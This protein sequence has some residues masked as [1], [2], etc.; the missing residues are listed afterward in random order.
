MKKI[1]TLIFILTVITFSSCCLF[2]K[3]EHL[4]NNLYL[5]E[6]DKVDRRI[7]FS[8]KKCSGSGVEI[9]PMTVLEISYNQKWIIAKTGSSYQTTNFEYWIIMNYYEN[10]PNAETIKAN[11]LGPMNNE[12]FLNELIKKDIPL[13]LRVIDK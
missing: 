8:E 5:S 9:V 10:T 6:F 11:T 2:I 1:T 7:L 13:V 3:E 12:V 4:G